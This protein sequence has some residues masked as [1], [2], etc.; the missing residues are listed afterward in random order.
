MGSCTNS[1]GTGDW[2]LGTMAFTTLIS[3]SALALHLDEEEFA[4]VDCRFKLDDESWGARGYRAGHIPGAVYADLNRDLSAPR[5]GTNGRHPLP[6]VE[7]LA[8]RLGELG[9]ASGVQV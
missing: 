8:K 7:T 5:T 6:D 3:T 1:K 2:G 4:I 9:I